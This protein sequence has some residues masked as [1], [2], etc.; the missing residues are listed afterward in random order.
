MDNPSGIA[1]FAFIM[2]LWLADQSEQNEKKMHQIEKRISYLE[3][4]NQ[5]EKQNV[6]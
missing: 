5:Q 6:R 3:N 2:V 4:T 1:I